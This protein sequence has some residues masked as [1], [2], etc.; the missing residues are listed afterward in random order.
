MVARE[1]ERTVEVCH[2]IAAPLK[3]FTE[4]LFVKPIEYSFNRKYNMNLLPFSA[5]YTVKLKKRGTW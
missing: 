5:Q 1:S 4:R 2:C 3:D